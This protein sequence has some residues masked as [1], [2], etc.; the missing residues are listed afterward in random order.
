MLL[1]IML[2]CETASQDKTSDTKA[3]PS[4]DMFTTHLQHYFL[5]IVNAFQPETTRN[6]PIVNQV[7]FITLCS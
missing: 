4:L 2:R 6:T 7:G 5:F 1:K 3:L